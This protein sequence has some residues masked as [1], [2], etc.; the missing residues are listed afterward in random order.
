MLKKK[1]VL[2]LSGFLIACVGTAPVMAAP[3]TVPNS[4]ANGQVADATK[5]MDNFNA[6]ADCAEGGVTTTG[7]PT[8]GSIAI[9]S[10]SNTITNGNLSGDVSTTGGTATTLSNSGVVA[11]SYMNANITVDAKGRITAA[12]SGNSSGGGGGG[13][14]WFSP[15]WSGQLTVNMMDNL[16]MTMVDDSSVGLLLSITPSTAAT[17]ADSGQ[18]MGEAIANPSADWEIKARVEF[19]TRAPGNYTRWGLALANT[20][21]NKRVVFGWDSRAVVYW[22]YMNNPNGYGGTEQQTGW[23]GGG[24]PRWLRVT[25][26]ATNATV[27]FYAGQDGKGWTLIKSMSDTA[28]LGETPKY[29]GIGFDIPDTTPGFDMVMSI[30]HWY[31][32]W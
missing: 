1:V 32:S 12:A 13:E 25:H 18:Y 3:C 29:V 10:G 9:I 16:T 23:S 30:G 15:P 7:T 11:G 24:Y 28:W 22:G 4:I 8:T 21:K 2:S 31:Q 6:V 5:I 20:S 14:W 27:N 19:P 26:S 17:G